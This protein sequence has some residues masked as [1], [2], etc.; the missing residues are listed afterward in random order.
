MTTTMVGFEEAYSLLQGFDFEDQQSIENALWAFQWAQCAESTLGWESFRPPLVII[1][2][3]QGSGKTTLVKRL[4]PGVRECFVVPAGEMNIAIRLG[5]I[6]MA[7]HASVN[8]DA[9][10]FEL[11]NSDIL[12]RFLTSREWGFKKWRSGEVITEK[13]RTMVFVTTHHEISLS[14][15]MAKRAVVI[16]LGSQNQQPARGTRHE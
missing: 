14:P 12:S 4:A 8:F 1:T 2:G 13:L 16:R 7:R 11:L 10:S 15:E 6:A 5:R 9:P 3:P